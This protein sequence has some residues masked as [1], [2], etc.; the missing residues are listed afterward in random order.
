MRLLRWLVEYANLEVLMFA[1]VQ[2]MVSPPHQ[3]VGGRLVT[4]AG[5]ALP[6]KTAHVETT[7]SGG[8]ARTI[9]TQRF[10][11]DDAAGLSVRYLLP[12]PSDGVVS[13]FSFLIGDRRIVGQIDTVKQARERFETAMAQGRTAGLVE[14]TRDSVFQ[15]EIGN[16][17]P[18]TEVT[19][20]ITVDQPLRWLEEGAWEWRFPTVVGQRYMGRGDTTPDSGALTVDVSEEP[21]PTGMT[22][23]LSI[24]DHTTSHPSSPSHALDVDDRDGLN[25]RFTSDAPARLD[26]DLVVRW[27]VARAAVG[28]SLNAAR[29]ATAGGEDAAHGLLTIVP[30]Q[31]KDALPCLPRDLICLI[32]TSGSM[33]GRPLAQAQR[34][35][36]ALVDRLGDDDR[37]ELIEFNHQVR[38]FRSEPVP[39]TTLGKAA[40]MTWLGSLTAG[41]ATEMHTAVLAAL[42]PLRSRAQRQ[43]ILITDGHIG[44]EQQIV[45]ELIENLP[46]T[47]RLHT[48]GV[49]TS[50]NRTLTR[51]AARAGGGAEIIVG[52][53]EDVE[54]VAQRLIVRTSAPLVTNLVVEGDALRGV[55]PARVPD[56]FA[57][58]PVRLALELHP[59]G[60]QLF[61]RGRTV[62]GVFEHRLDAPELSPGQGPQAVAALYG[63]ERVED[64]ETSITAVADHRKLNAEIERIG[65]TF[66]LATRLTSW[67]AISEGSIDESYSP[68]RTVTM[69]HEIPHG[70]SVVGLGLRQERIMDDTV[71]FMRTHSRS[72]RADGVEPIRQEA[73]GI[74]G[75]DLRFSLSLSQ[76]Q[77]LKMTPQLQQAI[78]LLALSRVDL[79]DAVQDALMENPLL[80][81]SSEIEPSGAQVETVA[82]VERHEEKEKTADVEL[83]DEMP[84]ERQEIDWEAYFESYSSPL[85]GT[86]AQ[87]LRDDDLPGYEATLTRQESLFDH[88][89]WQ[90]QVSDFSEQEKQVA[91]ALIGNINDDGYLKGFDAEQN[92]FDGNTLIEMVAKEQGNDFEY[93]EEILERVQLFDPPGVGA[94]DL[95]ECLLIQ[96]RYIELGAIVEDVISDHMQNLEKKNY[97]AIARGIGVGLEEIIEAAQLICQLEPRPGRPFANDAARYITPDIYIL[98]NDEGEY[99]ATLNDDGMPR[100]RISRFYR[101]ALRDANSSET[102]KYVTEKL[103][104]AAWLIRSI[105]QRQKTIVK[106]TQ[107]IIKFQR[108]FLDFGVERLKPL[109]MKDV[110]DDIEM[111]ESTV[112]RVTSNKYVHTP[113]GMFELK[114]F[115][116]FGIQGDIGDL[117][118]EV[119]KGKIK[120]L[121]S[122]EDP[123][124]PFSDQKLVDLLKTDG[125][126]I[127]R[128]TVAKYREALN[129]LPSSR[130][131]RGW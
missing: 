50:V 125:V 96:A 95:R 76:R 24:D 128:R 22:L 45:K 126:T 10:V 53:E 29:S 30:P 75:L 19:C 92:V 102:K 7:A 87:R 28:A 94:R 4:T 23:S 5:Q 17:P 114:Y 130:R 73:R 77:E 6:L 33:S 42:R 122:G 26:R 105:E 36:A 3:S 106:V 78:K 103:N 81:V 43:V 16:I 14:Q 79:I 124:N 35:V 112:S 98:K 72:G 52:L 97:P 116:E 44:F 60:G 113:Q 119:I 127:A 80:E 131:K 89:A 68:G 40:A 54:R 51:G 12:L 8:L 117:A 74:G 31:S 20:E 66:G 15:E 86:G 13:G 9:L 2:S 49:G 41:G 101:N 65:L 100:L 123:K 104:S 71:A 39:A 118:K 69:P 27:F 63:R 115:F 109:I 121:V 64:L 18:K 67:V 59:E 90:L 11:N 47:S 56:L 83:K 55:A 38:R 91:L 70:C 32:D 48:V 99:Q 85:P 21:M 57:G 88:L 110:A 108:E 62:D 37:L 120:Q 82:D 61:V 34:V 58:C 111:H 25:V 107:S 46:E 129:I 84:P 93:V 1:G